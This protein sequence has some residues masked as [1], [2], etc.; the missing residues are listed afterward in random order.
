[1]TTKTET[2]P[3]VRAAEARRRRL[4]ARLIGYGQWDPWRDAEPVRA[5]VQQLM[6]ANLPLHRIATGS[7]VTMDTL[8]HLMYGSTGHA[9][10]QKLRKENAEKILAFRPTLDD[11]PAGSTVPTVGSRRRLRALATHGWSVTHLA[12]LRNV[13]RTRFERIMH[14]KTTSVATARL[15]RDVYNELWHRA[16]TNDEVPAWVVKRIR[17]YAAKQGWDGPLAWD[18]DTI[19]D[20]KARPVRGPQGSGGVDTAKVMRRLEGERIDLNSGERTAAIEYGARTR[21]LTFKAIA[22]LLD[23]ELDSVKRSWE[24]IKE[25]ARAAGETWPESPRW[26]DPAW[27]QPEFQRAV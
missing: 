1:M 25:R 21:G 20:P 9:P 19:D 17:A 6:D 18:D 22:D 13:P 26:T 24:R 15:V 27:T 2:S 5:Y 12:E 23:M 3:A 4:R 8:R 11:Y 7:T 14:N 16:P 10:A